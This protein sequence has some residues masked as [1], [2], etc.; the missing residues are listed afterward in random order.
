MNNKVR[1]IIF[2]GSAGRNIIY[3]WHVR[4]KPSIELN[5]YIL[6]NCDAH[7]GELLHM[8]KVIIIMTNAVHN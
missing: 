1:L 4:L 6:K 8:H 2:L 5:T 7:N 3:N